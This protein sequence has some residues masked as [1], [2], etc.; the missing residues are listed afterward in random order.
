MLLYSK[1]PARSAHE[2]RGVFVLTLSMWLMG[3]ILVV[4]LVVDAST[5][6]R[7]RQLVQR[8]V[9]LGVISG[10]GFRAAK[11]WGYF[12]GD[13]LRD[14][15]KPGE[16]DS[17]VEEHM[18]DTVL[19]NLSVRGISIPRESVS[20]SF[21]SYTDRVE[22][23]LRY[24]AP[25]L[26]VSYVPGIG[27]CS[28]GS[29]TCPVFGS[30]TA[31]LQPANIGLAIDTS[32]SMNCPATEAGS[33][34]CECLTK[35]G[36][37]S[38]P[39]SDRKLAYLKEAV[40]AFI[41][42]FNPN[43]DRVVLGP[44]NTVGKVAFS[45]K[46]GSRKALPFGFAGVHERA[47]DKARINAF[48][49][50][51]DHLDAAGN[52]N[53]CDGISRAFSDLKTTEP[54]ITEESPTFLVLF[55][56]G[57]PSAGRF[58]FTSYSNSLQTQRASNP[59]MAGDWWIGTTE[60]VNA[61]AGG[62]VRRWLGPSPLV[63]IEDIPYGYAAGTP[64]AGAD[65][66]GDLVSAD[67]DFPRSFNPCLRSFRFDGAAQIGEAREV[68]GSEG[69]RDFDHVNDFTNEMYYAQQFYY[70]A[71]EAAD[72][73]REQAGGL[74][75]TIGLGAEAFKGSVDPLQNPTDPL[76]RKEYL[77]RR[78]AL[79]RHNGKND[80]P[81]GPRRQITLNDPND[82]AKGRNTTVGY[83]EYRNYEV[84][85]RDPVLR[86]LEGSYEGTNDPKRL[87]ALFIR[88]AKDILIRLTD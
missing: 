27:G 61:E 70:C 35:D 52:T 80:P 72:A 48:Y 32:G 69:E 76:R 82:S 7:H 26:L 11:G 15:G 75:Y 5:L 63:Q 43:R 17:E 10:L 64:P 85:A 9:D 66:C 24:D 36:C 55:S 29:H 38:I 53:I 39:V 68:S 19:A 31:E 13:D 79:D 46:D 40:K 8:S 47:T 41:A 22:V 45:V 21:S 88:T 25:L 50:E 65:T 16:K 2:E 59:A 62:S 57:A 56:D 73:I 67:D 87:K 28:T 33:A 58:H 1:T 3:L 42:F 6:Y 18:R 12:H 49:D 84:F 14:V 86:N 83:D 44:F 20:A 77:L 4:C 30:A 23:S 71:I 34:G 37:A 60:W 51:I 81:F 78:I 54:N 74:V